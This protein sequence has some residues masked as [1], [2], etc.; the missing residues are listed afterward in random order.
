MTSLVDGALTILAGAVMSGLWFG[1]YGTKDKSFVRALVV[2]AAAIGVQ[3]VIDRSAA[4]E[5]IYAVSKTPTHMEVKSLMTRL[6]AVR[7]ITENDVQVLTWLETLGP[8][9]G[10]IYRLSGPSGMACSWCTWP[11]EEDTKNGVSINFMVYTGVFALCRV[12]LDFFALTFAAAQ[13]IHSSRW[14]KVQSLILLPPIVEFVFKAYFMDAFTFDFT[15]VFRTITH[16]NLLMGAAI[17][18]YLEEHMWAAARTEAPENILAKANSILAFN[19]RNS[20]ALYFMSTLKGRDSELGAQEQNYWKKQEDFI[21]QVWKSVDKKLP[22][23]NEEMAVVE[24]ALG[25]LTSRDGS[26]VG[27]TLGGLDYRGLRRLLRLPV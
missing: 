23:T 3:L 17:L 5:D 4:F 26:Q 8:E 11:L 10:R 7:E 14:F 20:G 1:G 19:I 16:S 21:Q 2:F 13:S 25:T 22:P 18:V 12:A 6:A 15:P 24:N 27:Y 9:A